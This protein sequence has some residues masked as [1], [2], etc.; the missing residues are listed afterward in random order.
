MNIFAQGTVRVFYGQ[1]LQK[2]FR[3]SSDTVMN[4]IWLYALKAEIPAWS[5]AVFQSSTRSFY[6]LV[7]WGKS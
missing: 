4:E 1:K 3:Q 5:G 2:K 6:P 7:L